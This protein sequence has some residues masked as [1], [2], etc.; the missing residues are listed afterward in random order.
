MT[1]QTVGDTTNKSQKPSNM[2][3]WICG[4]LLVAMAINYVHRQT[5]GILKPELMADFKIDERGYADLVFWFQ[6]AYAIGYVSF[7]GIIDRVGSRIGYAVA[8]TVWCIAHM[9]TGL[10]TNVFQLTMARF[11]LGIGES[12]SFPASIKSIALWFPQKERAQAVGIFN[13]GAAIGAIIAPMLVP[14]ITLMWGWRS[15]FLVTGAVA[16]IWVVFWLRIYKNPRDHKAVNE[17]EITLIESDPADNIK[18][19]PWTKLLFTKETWAYALGKFLID[20]V[21]WFYLFWLPGFLRKEHNVSVLEFGP[22]LVVIYLISDIGSVGG[23]WLSSQF[24]KSGMSVNMARK[25]TL[26]IAAL[27]VLPVLLVDGEKDVWMAVIY[28]GIATAA[29]QAFSANLYTLPSDTFPRAA[30]GSVIGIGGAVGAIG[31]MIFSKVAGEVLETTHSYYFLFLIAGGAY[32]AAL[33]VIHFLSPKLARVTKFDE[34]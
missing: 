29:H 5:I 9:F 20:P 25:I 14:I 2:R 13:A 19:I 28:L 33:L 23:G 17:A 15:S 12:S 18:Q 31:G 21:W 6:V 22:M 34:A 3:W 10:A 24:I 27:C 7:G 30:V 26:L 32:L 11:A 16:L 8:F 1:A 4:L